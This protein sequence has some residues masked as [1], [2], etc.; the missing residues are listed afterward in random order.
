MRGVGALASDVL[1]P[2]A[3]KTLLVQG[4][5]PPWFLCPRNPR[6]RRQR[7]RKRPCNKPWRDHP[8]HSRTDTPN[9]EIFNLF[10]ETGGGPFH[11]DKQKPFRNEFAQFHTEHIR[12]HPLAGKNYFPEKSP[13][14][15]DTVSQGV[16]RAL[17]RLGAVIPQTA[18]PQVRRALWTGRLCFRLAR[19][20]L[21]FGEAVPPRADCRHLPVNKAAD[22]SDLPP[23]QS[24][25]SSL[26][27]HSELQNNLH[28]KWI[29]TFNHL[30]NDDPSIFRFECPHCGQS[31]EVELGD[32]PCTVNCPACNNLLH[33]PAARQNLTASPKPSPPVT[34]KSEAKKHKKPPV[35]KPISSSKNKGDYKGCGGCL[36]IIVICIFALTQ[37]HDDPPSSSRSRDSKSVEWNEKSKDW[38]IGFAIGKSAGRNEA[39]LGRK[40]AGRNTMQQIMQRVEVPPGTNHKDYTDGFIIGYEMGY[41]NFSK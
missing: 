41:D 24:A 27:T 14:P 28:P 12:V 23:K 36:V 9:D 25:E 20:A 11:A 15:A 31:L 2:R 10:H 32:A 3:A 39:N 6:F 29:I 16:N 30:M 13:P 8:K 19:M 34:A 21:A 4:H 7:G 35:E 40:R 22:G 17:A 18:A 26:F 1:W 38:R 33:L 37:C 5:G